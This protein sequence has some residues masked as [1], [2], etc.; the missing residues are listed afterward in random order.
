MLIPLSIGIIADKN[1]P[2]ELRRRVA[3]ALVLGF[4]YDNKYQEYGETFRKLASDTTEDEAIRAN[5]QKILDRYAQIFKV[6]G[7]VHK[8]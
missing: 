4:Y 3:D 7:D 6:R 1:K 5:I 2:I 8:K